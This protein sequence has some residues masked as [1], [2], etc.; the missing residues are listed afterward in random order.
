MGKNSL[1]IL[2]SGENMHRRMKRERRTVEQMISL[3]CRKQHGSAKGTFCG[4]CRELLDYAMLRLSRCPFQE[5]KTTCGNCPVHCYKPGMRDKIR[6]VMRIAGPRMLRHHPL[7]A[8]GHMID[9]LRREPI[10]RKK[11]KSS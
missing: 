8:I 3:Y 4:E 5:G 10:R 1:I 11:E 7:L 6:E 9:G 2:E